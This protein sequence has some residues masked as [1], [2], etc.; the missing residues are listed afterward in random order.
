[1]FFDLYTIISTL[2][3][4]LSIFFIRTFLIV[5]LNSDVISYELFKS[6]SRF[7]KIV[8][9]DQKLI[10]HSIFSSIAIILFISLP[11]TKIVVLF[12]AYGI[13]PKTQV[14]W[15]VSIMNMIEISRVVGE[16]L[17]IEHLIEYRKVYKSEIWAL[18][19]NNQLILDIFVY[20]FFQTNID[21]E[22]NVC[23]CFFVFFIAQILSNISPFIDAIVKLGFDKRKINPKVIPM[24]DRFEKLVWKANS[25]VQVLVLTKLVLTRKAGLFEYLYIGLLPVIYL[26][27]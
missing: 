7:P 5:L 13:V 11:L 24:V 10:I 8:S 9:K 4:F 27:T 17:D 25:T 21:N 12:L 15:I 16:N 19:K 23:H 3:C 1:M 26:N 2:I 22:L 6:E 20:I 18:I 14:K